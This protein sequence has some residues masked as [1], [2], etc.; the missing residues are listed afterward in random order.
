LYYSMSPTF[1]LIGPRGLILT[2]DLC[3]FGI[4]VNGEVLRRERERG[5]RDCRGE[6]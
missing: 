1:I 5:L 2:E 4:R 6:K 3:V